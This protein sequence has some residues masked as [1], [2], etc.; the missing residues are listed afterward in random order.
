MPKKKK[1][2][3]RPEGPPD[4]SF[5]EI[6]G[7]LRGKSAS[8]PS[9]STSGVI[10]KSK[11]T[12]TSKPESAKP[13][14]KGVDVGK[15]TLELLEASTTQLLRRK[16]WFRD[17]R[18][19]RASDAFMRS[20]KLF[21]K[22]SARQAGKN[23]SFEKPTPA[24]LSAYEEELLQHLESLRNKI[25]AFCLRDADV[26]HPQ[27]RLQL[28]GTVPMNECRE[29]SLKSSGPGQVIGAKLKGL[30]QRAAELE[31]KPRSVI[32]GAVR[33]KRGR[34]MAKKAKDGGGDE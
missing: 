25:G 6:N 29:I 16:G 23:G 24:A 10:K 18:L 11:V 12:A 21:Q 8:E 19:R 7:L 3:P 15:L 1:G 14:K 22:A 5:A 4:A 9:T 13:A 26:P 32:K 33:K 30:K 17:V 34:T 2:P 28:S 27:L 20:C 31:K